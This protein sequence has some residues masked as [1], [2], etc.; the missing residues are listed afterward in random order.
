MRPIWVSHSVPKVTDSKQSCFAA[1]L[2]FAI[3]GAII[4]A[5]HA[6]ILTLGR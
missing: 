2:H 3:L 4:T 6:G 1:N 5:A